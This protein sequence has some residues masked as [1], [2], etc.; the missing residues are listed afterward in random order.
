MHPL[1]TIGIRAARQA[2]NVLMRHV[3]RLDTLTIT[4]K[5]KNDFVSEVDRM[6]EDAI[7]DTI[8]EAYPNHGIK[9]E[10]GHCR[11]GSDDIE[12]IIDP[13]DGTTNYLRGI[14]HYAISIAARDR[15]SSNGRM[16]CG[17]VY[18]PFREELFTASRGGGAQLNGHRLRVRKQNGLDGALLATGLPFRNFHHR[19]TFLRML[20]DMQ[21]KTGDIRRAGSAALDLAYVAAGRLDGYWEMGL[22]EWDIAAGALLVQEAGGLVGDFEGGHTHIETGN[23]VAASPKVFAATLRLLG[24]HY[25]AM[26]KN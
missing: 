21:L 23:I 11:E 16:E 2:G 1:L 24:P 25:K 19:Q 17:V 4:A 22:Q 13:L 5:G 15:T 14:P 26:D 8:L 7:V 20:D 10:E 6:A 18:D 9:A 12:W 3:D